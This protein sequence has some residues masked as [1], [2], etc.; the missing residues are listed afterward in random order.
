MK[1]ELLSQILTKNNI[2]F[3]ETKADKN[4]KKVDCF[5]VWKGE[6]RPPVCPNI[7]PDK[8]DDEEQVIKTIEYAFEKI[9]V[10]EEMLQKLLDKDFIIDNCYSCIRRKSDNEEIIKWTVYGDLE[11]YIRVRLT[12]EA[13]CIITKEMA[14]QA[15]I[16]EFTN[17]RKAARTNSKATITVRNL[18]EVISEM[19]MFPMPDDYETE[20]TEGQIYVLSCN[21]NMNGASAML[22]ADV[23]TDLAD[24][25]NVNELT[26]LP[27]S[28][29]EVLVYTGS[30]NENQANDMVTSVNN[31]VVQDSDVLSNHIYKFYV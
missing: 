2:N 6:E 28:I 19:Q 14:M 24:K 18:M 5:C 8:L 30:M 7:Y 9:P 20:Y 10:K 23:L 3:E 22:H 25:C 16:K 1:K 26:I 15:D 13:N 31:E 17:L 29:H 4:G 27:S 12:D 21:N 11:E